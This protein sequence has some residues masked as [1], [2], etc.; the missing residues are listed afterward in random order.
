[1]PGDCRHVRWEGE[2]LRSRCVGW[3]AVPILTR[4]LP[5]QVRFVEAHANEK[6]LPCSLI[7]CASMPKVI[8]PLLRVALVGEERARCRLIRAVVQTIPDAGALF[9]LKN[10]T[11][12]DVPHA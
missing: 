6:R 10:T 11:R 7:Q 5:I 3:D 9:A 4:E 12:G 1:M 8:D 2:V